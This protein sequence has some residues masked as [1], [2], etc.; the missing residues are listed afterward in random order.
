MA[1]DL[2]GYERYA[3]Y[4]APRDGTALADAGARWLGRDAAGAA[5]APLDAAG[6]PA[7]RETLVRDAR[8]YGFHATL[9]AP[10]RLAEDFR[11][12]DLDDAVAAL[13]RSRA[14]I[15]GPRLAVG[16]LDGFVALT[17]VADWPEID[18][19]AAA[20]VTGLDLMRAPL[21]GPEIAR[22]RRAGLDTVEDANLRTWGYPYVL[23]R[24]RFHMTLTIRLSRVEAAQAVAALSRA[25]GPALDAPPVVED[26]CLFGDPGGGAPLRLL[27]RHPL[28]G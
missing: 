28:G 10:F 21:S 16:A 26:L 15:V 13:A 19:L 4:V 25:F 20:C 2:S 23:A 12:A 27:R 18:D 1:D 17:P 9:K 11:G 5:V 3:V 14:P 6:L 24:F 7:P 8:R 22:R